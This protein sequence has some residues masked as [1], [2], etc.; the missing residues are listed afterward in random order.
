MINKES[1]KLNIFLAILLA[2]IMP[3]ITGQLLNKFLPITFVS[4]P[5]HSAIE[6][7]GRIIAIVI[8]MIFYMK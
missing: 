6:S 3:I 2:I 5:I 4:I 7:A 1:I 8:S